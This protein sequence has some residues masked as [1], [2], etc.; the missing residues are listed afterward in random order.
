M[1]L[2]IHIREIKQ[3]HLLAIHLL[4]LERLFGSCRSQCAN[5]FVSMWWLLATQR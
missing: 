4:L 5:P 3:K 2:D 1:I